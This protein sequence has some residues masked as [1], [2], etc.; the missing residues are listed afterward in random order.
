MFVNGVSPN[1]RAVGAFCPAGIANV[2]AIV[3]SLTSAVKGTDDTCPK[4]PRNTRAPSRQ[5]H[6]CQSLWTN[7][8]IG[9]GVIG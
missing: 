5:S 8:Y 2:K 1:S 9:D 3:L 4:Y 6:S 7:V